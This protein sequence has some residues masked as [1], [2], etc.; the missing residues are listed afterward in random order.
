MLDSKEEMIEGEVEREI[1]EKKDAE[2]AG[3]TEWGRNEEGELEYVGTSKAWSKL[4]DL[5]TKE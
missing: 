1:L 3:L 5:Q 4:K 2:D